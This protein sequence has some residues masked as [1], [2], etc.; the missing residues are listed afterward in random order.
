MQSVIE[1]CSNLITTCWTL[2]ILSERQAMPVLSKLTIGDEK[3]DTAVDP[4]K[5]DPPPEHEGGRFVRNAV[6][7]FGFIAKCVA[8]RKKYGSM[9]LRKV[10]KVMRLPRSTVWDWLQRDEIVLFA[11]LPAEKR[12]VASGRPPKLSEEAITF[13]KEQVR[14]TVTFFWFTPP[15]LAIPA[16]TSKH[17]QACWS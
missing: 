6:H 17:T 15:K 14:P 16:A 8:Y 9:P 12:C 4:S 5:M 10:C 2:A 11:S 1:N 7:A 13:V 3:N